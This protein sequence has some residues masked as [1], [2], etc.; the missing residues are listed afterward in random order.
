MSDGKHV[1]GGVESARDFVSEPCFFGI[2]G[3]FSSAS[4]GIELVIAA[5]A[6]LWVYRGFPFPASCGI[7]GLNSTTT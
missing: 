2:F 3:R 6:G 4:C 7:L 5:V 1:P